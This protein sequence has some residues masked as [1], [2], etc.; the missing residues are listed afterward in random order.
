MEADEAARL[1]AANW[2]Y[3]QRFDFP[4]IIAVRGQRDRAAILAAIE[5][6]TANS[7][8]EEIETAI[9]EVAKIAWFRLSDL[10]KE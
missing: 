6:R 5:T 3:R 10:V 7:E 8:T 2:L 4:F 9:N 1:S